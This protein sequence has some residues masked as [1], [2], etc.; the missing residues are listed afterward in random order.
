MQEAKNAASQ[1]NLMANI[2]GILEELEERHKEKEKEKKEK[3]KEKK[4]KEKEKKEKKERFKQ[5][6]LNMFINKVREMDPSNA[7]VVTYD[8][9]NLLRNE[10]I[11]KELAEQKKVLLGKL[12]EKVSE[13]ENIL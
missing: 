13:Q 6:E 5:M 7:F 1:K 4:E 11:M 8:D 2:M 10:L 9:V 12:Q 3:E